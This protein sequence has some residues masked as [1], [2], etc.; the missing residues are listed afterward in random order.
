MALN[1]CLKKF[2]KIAN[3]RFFKILQKCKKGPLLCTFVH[4]RFWNLHKERLFQIT[5]FAKSRNN[6]SL[7]KFKRAIFLTIGTGRLNRSS[8]LLKKGA[9]GC[10]F[11]P[12]MFKN[13]LRKGPKWSKNL[14][15]PH[16]GQTPPLNPLPG[17]TPNPGPQRPS[18]RPSVANFEKMREWR[19]G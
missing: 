3:L 2:W 1:G 19:G 9:R 18:G 16:F 5:I 8:I 15:K 6:H 14:Q 13:F 11:R 12:A 4:R 10:K 7:C 17:Q